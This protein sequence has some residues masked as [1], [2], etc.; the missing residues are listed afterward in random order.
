MMAEQVPP[1]QEEIIA[2]TRDLRRPAG[3]DPRFASLESMEANRDAFITHVHDTWKRLHVRSIEE[4]L[5]IESIVRSPS[6]EKYPEGFS[7]LLKYVALIWRRVND[8]IVWNMYNMEGHYIRRLSLRKPRPLLTE[9]NAKAIFPFLNEINSDPLT[10]ALWSDATCCVDVGDIVTRSFS[11]K[12]TGI[13]EV[14]SGKVNQAIM[15]V[16]HSEDDDA[17]RHKA[18]ETLAATYGVAAI[19]QLGRVLRQMETGSQVS[20][21]L[22]TDKGFDPLHRQPIEILEAKTKDRD[23]DDSLAS[24]I[25]ASDLK[26]VFECIENCLWVY[27][28]QDPEKTHEDLIRDFTRLLYVARPSLREWNRERYD[29]D[30]LGEVVPLDANLLEPFAVPIFFRNFEPERVE[31]IVLGRLL[32]RVLL[33]FDWQSYAKVFEELGARLTWSTVK[34]ARAE[35]SVSHENRTVVIGN[36]IPIVTLETGQKMEGYSKIYRVFFEGILPSVVAAQYVEM[37]GRGSAATT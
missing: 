18:L 15:D 14:K 30:Y 34:R 21:V 27:I 5:K 4:I 19:K 10:I 23:Y 37:L 26:P 17:D 25:E 29:L 32:N 2:I 3:D 33:Y 8:A 1:I 35:S 28:D 7:G 24:F 11:G 36:R 22:R 9:S 6:A 13:I 20:E 16:I 31:Q 12:P